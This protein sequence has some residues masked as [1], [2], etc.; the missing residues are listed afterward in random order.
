MDE[1]DND[2]VD[3]DDDNDAASFSCLTQ[4]YGQCR[5]TTGRLSIRDSTS[6]FVYFHFLEAIKTHEFLF[7]IIKINAKTTVFCFEILFHYYYYCY[8]Y[9][10]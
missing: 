4:C 2:D 7:N 8:R 1:A 6:F 3:D 9:C 10:V 5:A